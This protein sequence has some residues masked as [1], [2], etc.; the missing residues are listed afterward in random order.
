MLLDSFQ[1]L[2][3]SLAEGRKAD[4]QTLS[5]ISILEDRLERLKA[6]NPAFAAISF[7]PMVSSL[8]SQGEDVAVS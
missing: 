1:I 6:L 8:V 2:Q 4:E 3:N 7:S 5:A